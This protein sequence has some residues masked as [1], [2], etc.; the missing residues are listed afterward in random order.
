M[1]NRSNGEG[2]VYHVEG[3]GWRAS[4]VV[5]RK[6]DGKLDRKEKNFELKAEAVRWLNEEVR[7]K[8]KGI[9]PVPAKLTV[10][11]FAKEWLRDVIAP[12]DQPNTYEFYDYSVRAH[13][14]PAIGSVRLTALR[15]AHVRKMLNDRRDKYSRRT[16]QAIHRT[17]KTILNW[18]VEERVLEYN[19]ANFKTGDDERVKDERKE[20]FTTLEGYQSARLLHAVET[21]P[22]R[23]FIIVAMMLG[24]RRGEVCA[25]RW[26]DIDFEGGWIKLRHSIVRVNITRLKEQPTK[27][28][29]GAGSRLA[30]LKCS[31]SA[32]ALEMSPSVR[33]ALLQRRDEQTEERKRAAENWREQD[34]IFTSEHGDHWH[35]D[36]ATGTFAKLRLLA[37]LPTSAATTNGKKRSVRLHDL[38][39]TLASRMTEKG[40]HP[41]RIQTQMGH[42]RPETTDWYTHLQLGQKNGI[43]ADAME[44]FIAEGKRALEEK[45]KTERPRPVQ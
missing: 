39:H 19:V 4:L 14:I 9:V 16:L 8:N 29:S 17:L 30:P 34:F 26:Q 38:R 1:G 31:E 18:G 20:N 32:R 3:R 21:H 12:R 27:R 45:R 11:M 25:L 40:V 33:A 23:C 41:K 22:W 37:E 35:P 43:V 24:I 13:L 44:E 28:F 10:E 15:S 6:P 7:K 2:S 5:G 42:Q 36:T